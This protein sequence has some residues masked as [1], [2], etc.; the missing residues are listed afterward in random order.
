MQPHWFAYQHSQEQVQ[1][2]IQETQAKDKS[3]N[4]RRLFISTD[5]HVG[6]LGEDAF[7]EWLK[8]SF[9]PGDYKRCTKKGRTDQL[10]F[11]VTKHDRDKMLWKVDVKTV[12]RTV[13]PEPEYGCEV[14]EVQISDPAVDCYVFSSHNINTSITHV[15]G[16]LAKEEFLKVAFSVKRGQ[17]VK[18]RNG[19]LVCPED[20]RM[21]YLHQL[22]PLSNLAQPNDMWLHI[23]KNGLWIPFSNKSSSSNQKSNCKDCPESL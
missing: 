21:C 8:I 4:A 10:D 2:A 14:A 9:L 11:L 23:E 15:L 6:S 20:M 12:K 16:W 5:R 7:E 3:P 13:P 22:W 19:Y 1:K 17:K 18:R